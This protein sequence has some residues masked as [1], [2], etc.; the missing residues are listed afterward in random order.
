MR[1]KRKAGVE[2]SEQHEVKYFRG[3]CGNYHRK[4]IHWRN[5]W[6][7]ADVTYKE[8]KGT[9]RMAKRTEKDKEELL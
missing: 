2:N 6:I 1:Q 5:I 3:K 7:L 9:K 4:K 8:K